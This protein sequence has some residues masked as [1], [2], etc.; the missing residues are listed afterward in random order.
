MHVYIHDN[1]MIWILQ[2]CPKVHLTL[3]IRCFCVGH[4]S[5]NV[6][7]QSKICLLTIL[8]SCLSVS[9]LFSLFYCVKT[10]IRTFN[11][12]PA[13]IWPCLLVLLDVCKRRESKHMTGL[14]WHVSNNN[15][16]IIVVK[17][18]T[19]METI[20]YTW[21]KGRYYSFLFCVYWI[22]VMF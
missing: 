5:H 13:S 22:H 15:P 4:F 6:I 8:L 12:S 14:I 21:K 9:P 10:C 1:G 19:A 7:C 18:L 16:F 20:W 17:A 2:M 3:D 11:L